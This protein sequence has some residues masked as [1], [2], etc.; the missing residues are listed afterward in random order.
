MEKVCLN[1]LDALCICPKL[2]IKSGLTQNAS[3]TEISGDLLSS[4]VHPIVFGIIVTLTDLC[5]GN[6]SNALVSSLVTVLQKRSKQFEQKGYLLVLMKSLLTQ[7]SELF[8]KFVMEG[9]LLK[10]FFCC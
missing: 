1:L 3:L 7:N 9:L 2:R 8:P 4:A 6:F 10:H 5:S